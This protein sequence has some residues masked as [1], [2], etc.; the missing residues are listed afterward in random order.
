VTRGRAAAFAAAG[1]VSLAAIP[2]PAGAASPGAAAPAAD[3][4]AVAAAIARAWV[5]RQRANGT[6]RDYVIAR[7]PGARDGYG[8][9]MLGAA[10]LLHGLRTGDDRAL[11]SGLRALGRRRPPARRRGSVFSDLAV[12]IGYAAARTRLR[13]DR[14]FRAI[15]P[16]IVAELRRIDPGVLANR[17]PYYNFHLVEATAVLVAQ[18]TGLRGGDGGLG[19]GR[20]RAGSLARSIL[21]RILPSIARRDVTTSPVAGTMALISDPPSD[22]PAYHAFTLGLLSRAIEA[23][24]SQAPRATV[25]LRDRAARATW[26]LMAPDGDVAYL[27]RSQEQSWT[28]AFSAYGLTAAA[29]TPGVA[30][31]QA[32]RLLGAA[33]RAVARLRAEYADD[34]VGAW[35]APVL[36]YDVGAGLR[37][38]DR[39]AHAAEYTGLTLLGLELAARARAALRRARP[40]LARLPAGPVG[41]DRPGVMRI[42]RG[43]GGFLTV[44][45][46]GVWYALKRRS[47]ARAR[48]GVDHSLD[49]RY[50]AGLAAV[51]V[52]RPDGGWDVVLPPRPIT[53][54]F[55]SAGPAREIAA[56]LARPSVVRLDVRHGG[57]LATR[58]RYRTRTG[59]RLARV[60]GVRYEPL[61]GGVRTVVAARRGER[62]RWSAFF[63][64]T[65]RRRGRDIVGDGRQL[66]VVRPAPAAIRLA[67]R[68]ASGSDPALRRVDFDIRATGPFSITVRRP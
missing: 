7:R 30:P 32:A 10:L 47:T 42:G 61:D 41:A 21:A 6:F 53:A 35:I 2:P 16:A 24:G 9:S 65:P 26:A 34:R 8:T 54:R 12:A 64:G 3:G 59:L 11:R 1:A 36:R 51:R 15:R 52:L 63:A 58:Q 46:P 56:G 60:V 45:S 13:E 20:T 39:Y 40:A 38:L 55:D 29:G 17:R 25:A 5:A 28:L 49:L 23:L 22:P 48:W 43:E 66:A 31:V 33:D 67:G 50:D 44:R 37:G 62:W 68:Y 14:R 18:A 4:D 27:G 19:S 57:V